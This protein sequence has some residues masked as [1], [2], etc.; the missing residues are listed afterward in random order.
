MSKID[1]KVAIVVYDITNKSS[2]EKLKMWIKEIRDYGP[3]RISKRFFQ[4]FI[5]RTLVIAVVG[6]KVDLLKETKAIVQTDDAKS[7]AKVSHQ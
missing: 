5:E 7:F 6:N 2:F 4:A 3:K 1:A